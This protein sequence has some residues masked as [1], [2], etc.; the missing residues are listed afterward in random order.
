MQLVNPLE[1]QNA[2]KTLYSEFVSPVCA[3]YGL[4]RIELDILL[5]LANNTRYD[6][7]TD[8]VE[9][10]FSK[11]SGVGGNQKFWKPAAACGGNTSWKIAKTAHLRC[12]T[13]R[14]R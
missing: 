10:V 5:F 4:T 7:A 1:Q 14:S 8:I 11:I 3:K 2:V 9:V 13:P 12:V 6:T